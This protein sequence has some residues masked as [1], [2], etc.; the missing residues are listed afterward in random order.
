MTARQPPDLAGE[1][2]TI[3]QAAAYVGLS[4]SGF[5]G[6]ADG[7]DIEVRRRGRRPGVLKAD[8]DAYLQRARI[9]PGTVRGVSTSKGRYEAHERYARS[10]DGYV[11]GLDE[12]DRL[13]ELGWNNTTIA[14]A[15]GIHFSNVSRR[16]VNGFNVAQVTELRRLSGGFQD[17]GF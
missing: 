3:D 1:W 12:V 14:Q 8:L 5:H 16:R 7:E 15:L 11:P 17:R 10:V 9:R 4:A 13:H 6:L 2:L